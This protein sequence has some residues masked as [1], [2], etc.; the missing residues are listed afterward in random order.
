MSGLGGYL[1]KVQE[2]DWT[3]AQEVTRGDVKTAR[4]DG[5]RT[6]FDIL[7][8]HYLTGDMADWQL[9]HEFAVASVPGGKRSIPLFR[10]TPK[11]R[12]QILGFDDELAP[13]MTDEQYA[14]MEVGGDLMALIPLRVWVKIRQSGSAAD[15]LAAGESG[16]LTAINELLAARGLGMAYPPWAVTEESLLTR[17][18]PMSNWRR[19]RSDKAVPE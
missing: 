2:G 12:R 10:L 1:N 4:R 9:W 18:V 5:S 15:V 17:R 16:G 11:L 19:R 13:P 3:V 6:P 8:D 14:A 7:R